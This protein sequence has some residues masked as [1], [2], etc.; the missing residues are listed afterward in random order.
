MSK[1]TRLAT[2][3]M[4]VYVTGLVENGKAVP[5][6]LSKNNTIWNWCVQLV[7]T[8]TI[9]RKH[10]K[11]D[12]F[13]DIKDVWADMQKDHLPA[14]FQLPSRDGLTDIIPYQLIRLATSFSNHYGTSFLKR[15]R[16]VVRHQ[17]GVLLGSMQLPLPLDA[18]DSSDEEDEDEDEDVDG[19]GDEDDNKI[20]ADTTDEDD[21]SSSSSDASLSTAE[22]KKRVRGKLLNL[23]TRHVIHRVNR[24]KSKSKAVK[25]AAAAWNKLC[26]MDH[27]SIP[28]LVAE[29]TRLVEE[30]QLAFHSTSKLCTAVD[31]QLGDEHAMN[32]PAEYVHYFSYLAKYGDA[33][34]LLQAEERQRSLGVDTDQEHDEGKEEK[35]D[36]KV[37]V[38]YT[39]ISHSLALSP[40]CTHVRSP[41]VLSAFSVSFFE[42]ARWR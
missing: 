19:D 28:K 11:S 20:A 38:P 3:L 29:T 22:K 4:T 39:S 37:H 17:L 8:Q 27:E 16:K 18:V 41:R 30:H 35:K 10:T 40:P 12:I 31:Q 9:K 34:R 42:A 26:D 24:W 7:S 25:R 15:Q 13:D 32:H 5:D 33:Q 23:C 1:I 21:D 36:D 14:N 6:M 2:M